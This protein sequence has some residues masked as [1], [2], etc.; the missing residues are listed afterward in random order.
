MHPVFVAFR[1]AD[2]DW[3][4]APGRDVHKTGTQRSPSVG[5][6]AATHAGAAGREEECLP[7]SNDDG[8]RGCG[9]W[10]VPSETHS[11]LS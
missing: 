6:I 4:A 10:R 1:Q 3:G 2:R 8:R 11:S 5:N 9:E 7:S